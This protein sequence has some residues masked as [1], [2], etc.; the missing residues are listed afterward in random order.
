MSVYLKNL[1]MNEKIKFL[2][3][4]GFNTLFGY[5]LFV[6]IQFS[7]GREITYIGSLYLAHLLASIVA[8]IL[9]RKVVFQVSGKILGDFLKFQSVYIVPL[10][11]NTVL[12][13]IFVSFLDWNVY[14]AQAITTIVLTI[15]SY[16]GHKFFSFR[17]PKRKP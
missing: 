16:L 5:V 13:P 10:L 17:R 8:F 15:G 2:F 3:V 1:F 4:G 7:I 9:Y 14:V 6:V 12:L 11:V